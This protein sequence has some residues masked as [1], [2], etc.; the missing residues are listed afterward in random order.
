MLLAAVLLGTSACADNDNKYSYSNL[1]NPGIADPLEPINRVSFTVSHFLDGFLIEPITRLY[2]FFAPKFMQERIANILS[3]MGEPVFFANN[4]MQ[5]EFEKAGI[6][7]Q[8]FAI[9]TI[10][11]VGGMF[12]VADELDLNQQRTDFGLTLA[13]WGFSSGPFLYIP[14]IGP[15][16]VRDGLGFGVDCFMTP[17]TYIAGYGGS[18]AQDKYLIASTSASILTN[19]A[20]VLDEYKALEESSLDLYA[21]LRSIFIQ[22]RNKQIGR[23]SPGMNPDLYF[24]NY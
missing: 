2:V 21:Q 20:A 8:R 10:V 4:I 3:N 15:S 13:S 18:S 22:Y 14:V 7:V 23:T 5:G 16:S 12:E 24:D 1:D 9:N 17:W 6:T 19:R 11:G